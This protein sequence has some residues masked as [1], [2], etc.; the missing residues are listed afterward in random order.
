[1][2]DGRLQQSVGREGER[3][4]EVRR[5]TLLSLVG[6][7]NDESVC[8]AE[9]V[10]LQAPQLQVLSVQVSKFVSAQPEGSL[11]RTKVICF[12][13]ASECCRRTACRDV[14]AWMRASR[15]PCVCVWGG[16]GGGVHGPRE[17]GGRL[18]VRKNAA[19]ECCISSGRSSEV[20]VMNKGSSPLQPASPTDP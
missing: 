5:I 8:R 12:A 16:G 13:S 19:S 4:V 20:C 3:E 2:A 11:G 6:G 18:K 10:M 9:V 7:A 14:R 15:W 17:G 1:M